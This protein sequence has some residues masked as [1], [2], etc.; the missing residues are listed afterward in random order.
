MKK[1][2]LAGLA[3]AFMV[4]GLTEMAFAIN[5]IGAEMLRSYVIKQGLS[6][7]RIV[8]AEEVGTQGTFF[9]TCTGSDGASLNYE[10]FIQDDKLRIVKSDHQIRGFIPS[11]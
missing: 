2:L 11:N 7:P 8:G 6:C 9:I 1:L 5:E 3:I 10:L 4:L